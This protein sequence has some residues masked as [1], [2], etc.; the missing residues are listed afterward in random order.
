MALAR[1]KLQATSRKLP[2]CFSSNYPPYVHHMI[3]L[4][5]RGIQAM[6]D[7][8]CYGISWGFSWAMK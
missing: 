2:P 6:V 7:H 8:R 5:V 1:G 3:T 4:L